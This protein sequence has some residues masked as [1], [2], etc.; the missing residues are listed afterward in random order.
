M[1]PEEIEKYVYDIMEKSF[2]PEMQHMKFGMGPHSTEASSQ[3]NNEENLPATVFETHDDVYVIIPIKDQSF[4]QEIKIS[5]TS[6][7]LI[8]ERIPQWEDKHTITL[9]AIVK[10]KGTKAN[11][12][13]G[14]LQIKLQKNIDIQFSEIDITP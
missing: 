1:R 10:K 4:L 8:I 12:Q 5:H 2:P 11:Y 13:D 14:T 9:P 6:N 7:Q 3:E